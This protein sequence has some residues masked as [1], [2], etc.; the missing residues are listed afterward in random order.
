[1]EYESEGGD[2]GSTRTNVRS[3]SLVECQSRS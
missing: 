2:A 1:M 3:P